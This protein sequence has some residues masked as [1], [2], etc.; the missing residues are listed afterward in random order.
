[1]WIPKRSA[2]A[3]ANRATLTPDSGWGVRAKSA[4]SRTKLKC[5]SGAGSPGRGE[6]GGK[7]E[8]SSRNSPFSAARVVVAGRSKSRVEACAAPATAR[9]YGAANANQTARP[10]RNPAASRSADP[11]SSRSRGRGGSAAAAPAM[12]VVGDGRGR[13]GSRLLL[14]R[15]PG[16]EEEHAAEHH[17]RLPEDGV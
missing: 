4:A 3:A 10:A 9:S 7:S 15:R 5:K 16:E 1:M 12:R 8:R 14:P 2:H 13:G 6:S 11:P 17:D